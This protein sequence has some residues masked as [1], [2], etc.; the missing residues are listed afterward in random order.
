MLSKILL[1]LH[2]KRTGKNLA[3]AGSAFMVLSLALLAASG[4]T[5][6][7]SG[8]VPKEPIAPVP[9]KESVTLVLYFGDDQAMEILPE[10]R[11]VQVP[12]DPNQRPP[13]EKLVVEELLKGPQDSLLRK[14][15]P[16]EAR[17]LSIQVTDGLALV[18]FSKEIQTKHWGGSAGESMTI[19]SLVNSLTELPSIQ[20]VQILV[21]G[22]KVETVAGHFDATEPFSRE[23]LK[24]DFFT[25]PERA[26]ALQERVDK[27]QDAW[28]KDP[29]EV[30]KYEGP[31]RGLLANAEYKLVTKGQ[32]TA[33]IEVNSSGKTYTVTLNQPQ[34][35]GDGG[36]WVIKTISAK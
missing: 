12:S 19:R 28:R 16:P 7:A 20:K 33:T 10:R 2:R 24:G 5:P 6:Q 34:K 32:G 29:I 21:E 26:K 17:L 11:T 13:M 9:S 36:I 14:T 22:K 1:R 23:V 27:G 15:L 8:S 25:S 3:I 31:A 35:Q 30:A 18:N 4:C